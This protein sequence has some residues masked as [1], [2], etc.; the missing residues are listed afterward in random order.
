MI[1]PYVPQ[2]PGVPAQ[3]LPDASVGTYVGVGVTHWISENIDQ[4]AFILLEDKP[5]WEIS[6]LDE[7]K[8][9]LWLPL[10]NIT[11]LESS[12]PLYP[13]RL[14]NSDER[15]T[16]AAKLSPVYLSKA[17]IVPAP[18]RSRIEQVILV[19]VMDSENKA[20]I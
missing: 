4:G 15:E 20:I 12:D 16:A 11:V 10:S 19:K 9:A 5:L 7:T 6:S 18:S 14:V 13:Y 1:A 2:V 17:P 3:S 8:T